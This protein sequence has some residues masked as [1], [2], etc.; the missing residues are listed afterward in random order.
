[1]CSSIELSPAISADGD[2]LTLALCPVQKLFTKLELSVGLIE[3]R[4]YV[5][6]GGM[7]KKFGD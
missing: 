6:H 1:L 4:R 5:P 3:C 7:S 2:S